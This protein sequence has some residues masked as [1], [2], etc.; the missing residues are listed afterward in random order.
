MGSNCSKTTFLNTFTLNHCWSWIDMAWLM[1][2]VLHGR[3]EMLNWCAKLG[4]KPSLQINSFSSIIAKSRASAL[5]TA[6]GVSWQKWKTTKRTRPL[7]NN[8]WRAAV[9]TTWVQHWRGCITSMIENG[10]S[11]WFLFKQMAFCLEHLP[12]QS[13]TEKRTKTLE[14]ILSRL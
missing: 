11:T 5:S 3:W 13:S 9:E 14:K 4:S 2:Y 6:C 7:S 10:R 8:I 1:R 12:K